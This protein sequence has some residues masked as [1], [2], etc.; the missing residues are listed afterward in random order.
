M[1]GPVDV[2][3]VGVGHLGKHHARLYVQTQGARL[4]GVVDRDRERA[5]AIA[6]EY[7][8]RVFDNEEDLAAN[9]TAVSVAVPTESHCDV[10]VKLLKAGVHVLV[11]KPIAR[12]LEEAERINTV[13]EEHDRIVM[14]GHTERFNPAVRALV[15]AVREPRF[16]EIHRLAA[17]SARSTDIDVVLDLMIHDLDLLLAL[18]GSEPL[19]VDAAGIAALTDKTDIANAR[20]R[21]ES[22]CVANLTASR[23]SPEPVRRIRVFQARTYLS[24]DTGR[25]V[26]NRHQLVLAE[27]GSPKILHDLL[28]ID[29]AEPLAAELAAFVE[30][31]RGG[32]RPSIDGRQG[33]RALEL[34][35]RV[36]EAI[37]AERDAIG[38]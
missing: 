30:S 31:V 15:D 1:T 36:H 7:G 19:T 32:E 22:G 20:I 6:S 35:H 17:F 23:I 16:F 2:G 37:A 26:V 3:V 28:P 11:E 18:D 10:A 8:C 5:A 4:V 34:A 24:C 13:A 38:S 21:F 12:S 14:V 9:T 27:D 33:Q 25:R 29:E